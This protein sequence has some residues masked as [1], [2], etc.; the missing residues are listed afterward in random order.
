MFRNRI[1]P[2]TMRLRL[3]RAMRC[4]ALLAVGGSCLLTGCQSILSL[5]NREES[6]SPTEQV[7]IGALAHR[8]YLNTHPPAQQPDQRAAVEQVGR[9]LASAS[10][11]PEMNWQF[12]VAVDR[13]PRVVGFP[14]GRI[15]V[16][17]ALLAACR[18]EAELAAAMSHEMGHLLAGH[19]LERLHRQR[20]AHVSRER[21]TLSP[22]SAFASDDPSRVPPHSLRHEAEADSIALSLL[23]QAGYDPD[24]AHAFWMRAAAEQASPEFRDLARLHP[25]PRGRLSQLETSLAQARGMYRTHP[26]P[27]GQGATLAFEVH[28]E[29][30][31]EAAP[32]EQRSA[33]IASTTNAQQPTAPSLWTAS[34]HRDGSKP[35]T[36][37]ADL[38]LPAPA[39][40]GPALPPQRAVMQAGFEQPERAPERGRVPAADDDEW[41]TPIIRRAD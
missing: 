32:I 23:V 40:P 5:A 29:Q 33:T 16:S 6:W 8:E 31:P 20:D 12:E 28:H 9:R 41:L 34:V 25:V 14:G 19:G 7:R 13:T 27:L 11:R 17:D 10:A 15:V 18:N 4:C 3:R 39:L 22:G 36:W 24:A 37:D 2:R 30:L 38:V 26:G 21:G 1:T 35:D